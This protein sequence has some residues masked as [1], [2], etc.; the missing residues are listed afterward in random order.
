VEEIRIGPK[1][2]CR[3]WGRKGKAPGR[4]ESEEKDEQISPRT[5]VQ[6]QKIAGTFL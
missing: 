4:K 1:K 5:Y 6:F 2:G 3:R